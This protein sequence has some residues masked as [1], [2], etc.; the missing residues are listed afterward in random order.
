MNPFRRIG[1]RRS[2]TAIVTTGT[3]VNTPKMTPT[4]AGASTPSCVSI[5]M[6]VIQVPKAVPTLKKDT[7]IDDASVGALPP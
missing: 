2:S 5:S 1:R 7:T 3:K 6:P 4:S